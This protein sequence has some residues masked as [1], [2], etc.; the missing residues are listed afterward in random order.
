VRQRAD[1]IKSQL[2]VLPTLSRV[3]PLQTYHPTRRF[4]PRSLFKGQSRQG[5]QGQDCS[6]GKGQVTT[7]CI[8]ESQTPSPKA[9]AT[10]LLDEKQREITP[11][12]RS[13][14]SSPAQTLPTW[15]WELF[16]TT[17][18]FGLL[19]HAA[20]PI[21]SSSSRVPYISPLALYKH[22]GQFGYEACMS[23]PKFQEET[24]TQICRQRQALSSPSSL[25]PPPPP[26]PFFNSRPISLSLPS[27]PRG[28]S[29]RYRTRNC[30][31]VDI[32]HSFSLVAP[33]NPPPPPRFPPS[34]G[35]TFVHAPPRDRELFC[36]SS[37]HFYPDFIRLS[38]AWLTLVN[39]PYNP[40]SHSFNINLE[41]NRYSS[42]SIVCS[43]STHNFQGTPIIFRRNFPSGDF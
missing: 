1:H 29:T 21:C 41:T 28:P 22:G 32:N 19:L 4:E 6:G 7:R 33:Y 13:R 34:L 23:A 31:S 16:I 10:L 12:L 11:R 25:T 17:F 30:S 20:Q 35:S 27:L 15:L 5:R 14:S 26:L 8:A 24:A 40:P 18:F 9:K 3:V 37:A 43:D 36:P 2:V 39:C 42:K 38:E